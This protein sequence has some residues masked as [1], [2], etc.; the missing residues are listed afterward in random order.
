MCNLLISDKVNKPKQ[1]LKHFGYWITGDNVEP[2]VHKINFEI[3]FLTQTVLTPKIFFCYLLP[4]MLHAYPS[5]CKRV[6][7][8]VIQKGQCISL[9][10]DIINVCIVFFVSL[11]LVELT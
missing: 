7:T 4:P 1:L 3:V 2:E 8:H 10:G 11:F 6:T 5:L 9:C